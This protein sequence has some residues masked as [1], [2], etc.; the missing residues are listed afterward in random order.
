MTARVS[1]DG[2]WLAFMSQR[3]LTGYD[4]HD[5]LSGEPDRGGGPATTAKTNIWRACSSSRQAHA[6][7]AKNTVP[8][9]AETCRSSA[10]SAS[11]ESAR[12]LAADL[13]AWTRYGGVSAARYQSRSL[14]NSG[15]MFF[16][17]RDALVPQDSNGTWDVYEYDPEGVP[18]ESAHSCSSAS[19]SGSEVF[20]PAR[21]YQVEGH[22]GVEPA[23][24]V[25]LICSGGSSGES[26]FMDTVK[27]AVTCSSPR[28]RSSPPR[29]PTTPTTS[30]TPT[31]APANAR[32]SP[33]RPPS[34][35]NAAQPTP[36]APRP[37]PRPS[38]YGPPPS[39]TFSGVGFLTP[40]PVVEPAMKKKAVNARAFVRNEKGKCVR[41]KAKHKGEK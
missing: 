13:P 14:S 7:P 17:S 34:P 1:P 31:N 37:N 25:G 32:A 11:W 41:A 27:A 4:N 23:G 18:A 16:N 28:P 8:P 6:P 9:T 21:A 20:R 12:W 2:H 30:T 3:E 35:R 5:A 36:A 24:C 33:H 19:T 22:S 26:W 39:A 40:A 15:R 29:T 38:L 10:N